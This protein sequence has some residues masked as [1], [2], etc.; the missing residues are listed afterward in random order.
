M[1]GYFFS[2]KFWDQL[3][4]GAIALQNIVLDFRNEI[5]PFNSLNFE[6]KKGTFLYKIDFD[7]RDDV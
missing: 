2:L 4:H 5:L 6:T 1:R 3:V 7:P